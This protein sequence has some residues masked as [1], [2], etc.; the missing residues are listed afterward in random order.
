[1]PDL[2]EIVHARS[3]DNPIM[4]MLLDGWIDAGSGAAMAATTLLNQIELETLVEFNTDILLDHRARR[5][6]MHLKDGINTGIT[7]PS[8]QLRAG[9]DHIGNDVIFLLGAE[10]DHHWKSF[11]RAV[12]DLAL[13]YDVSLLVGLGAY[14][15]PTPHT[16]PTRVVATATTQ[17]LSEQVGFVP[18]HLDIPAGIHAVLE[19]QFGQS[20]LSA[21][22]LW[23]QVP[24]YAS[25]MQYPGASAAL[26]DT[27]TQVTGLLFDAASLSEEANKTSER[28]NALI[29]D[30]PE[31]LALIKQLEKQV[32]EFAPD[33]TLSLLSGDELAAEFEK[34]LRDQDE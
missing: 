9:N 20:G 29:A 31:H 18:G 6:T 22:G 15:A 13:Q 17:E 32:D 24:H 4:I 8:I 12:A 33:S 19:Y 25:A 26:L 28:L 30:S 34:F 27:L 5:P 1:M 11:S 16:R 2:Y 7:W 10:P 21:I 3:M 23:A 14:P